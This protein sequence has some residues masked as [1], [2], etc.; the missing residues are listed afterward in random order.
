[1]NI[2]THQEFF[3]HKF[4]FPGETWKRIADYYNRYD[5]SNYGR[6]RSN[7]FQSPID[8]I[9]RR[10]IFKVR[11][12]SWNLMTIGY[13][14]VVLSQNQQSKSITVHRLVANAFVPN[15]KNK[16]CVNHIDGN[17][18][19]NNPNNLEWVTQSENMLHAYKT[20]LIK[21]DGS[22]HHLAKLTEEKVR[23]IKAII[24]NGW[25]IDIVADLYN[26]HKSTIHSILRERNWA[27]VEI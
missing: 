8:T 2:L 7:K 21:K 19:N 26:V 5:I 4:A 20:G 15:P 22:N 14:R 9:G 16:P 17:K 27:H 23:T 6:V 12:L 1:M 11:I 25:N 10:R 13:Y 24:I 18:L 3:N